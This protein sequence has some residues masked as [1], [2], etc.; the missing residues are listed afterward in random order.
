MRRPRT[1]PWQNSNCVYSLH[2]VYLV[3]LVYLVFL[4]YKLHV[5]SGV[6]SRETK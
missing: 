4:V 3:Y 5:L 2:C 1:W 6:D